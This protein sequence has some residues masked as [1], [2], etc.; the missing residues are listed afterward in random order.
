M[1]QK[2]WD[3][4]VHRATGFRYIGQV[5]ESDEAFARCAALYRFGLAEED[6][7]PGTEPNGSAIFPEESFDVSPA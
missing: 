3:V 4:R 7:T 2:T 6:A 5:T 1:A